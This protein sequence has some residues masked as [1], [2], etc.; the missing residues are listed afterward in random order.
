VLLVAARL[1]PSAEALAEAARATGLALADVRTR[2]AG[3][4]PR[5]LLTEPDPD[6]ARE[7][8]A[9]LEALGF[10]M[11]AC[12]PRAIPG[13]DDRLLARKLEWDPG[14]GLQVVDKR[15]ESEE[16][17]PASLLLI[18]KGVRA[19]STTEV[20]K[21]SERR[22]DLGRAVLS[23]GLLLTKKVETTSTK[24]MSS[25]DAFI[26]LHRGDGGR[27]VMIYERRIDY[28]FLGADIQPSS[29]ANFDRL[30]ARLRAW[31]PQVRF[32][33]RVSR[34]GFVSG[35]PVTSAAPVDLALWLVQ[36]VHLRG[37]APP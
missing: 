11:L 3:P 4:L 30:L 32:D 2:L 16:V 1:P 24:T 9:G 27:D 29:A 22:F 23:G 33:D 5:V 26:L 12:D 7:T 13:D 35:L 28:R 15:G 25:R 37:V 36:L 14:G 19:T 31:A 17:V 20:T 10:V 21:K 34:P 18:Q 8:A 6:R